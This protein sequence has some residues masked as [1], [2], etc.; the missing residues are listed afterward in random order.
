[1]QDG[2]TTS[3]LDLAGSDR[4]QRLRADLG[5]ES[6]GLNLI[7]LAPR[8]RGRIHAHERQE[9]VYVVLSGTL[10]LAT[11][12]K[13]EQEIGPNGCVRVAPGVRRQIMNRGRD[14][15]VLLAIGGAEQHHGRDGIAFDAWDA[16]EGRSPQETPMPPDLP[17]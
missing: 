4:F 15:C 2:I 11:G 9:E 1:M 3:S 10:T 8:Q 14:R 12:E 6:F 7:R 5:V 13:E 17:V 16:P